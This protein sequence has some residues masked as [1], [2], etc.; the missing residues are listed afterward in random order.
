LIRL[1]KDL[2]KTYAAVT[3]RSEITYPYLFPPNRTFFATQDIAYQYNKVQ[4]AMANNN[5]NL[6]IDRHTVNGS[7]PVSVPSYVLSVSLYAKGQLLR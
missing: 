6:Y 7:Y 3:Q 4:A 5:P 1:Q 2:N